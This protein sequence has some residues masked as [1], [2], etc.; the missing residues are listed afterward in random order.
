VGPSRLDA[1]WVWRTGEAKLQ[2]AQFPYGEAESGQ[3]KHRERFLTSG[4]CS[5][6]LGAASGALGRRHGGRGSPA[7]SSDSG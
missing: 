3:T 4:Q 7:N 6:R 2:R 1:M 5:G